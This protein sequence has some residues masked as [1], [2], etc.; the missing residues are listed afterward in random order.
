MNIDR[1]REIVSLCWCD[2]RTRRTNFDPALAD[3]FAERLMRLVNAADA[4]YMAGRWVLEDER[5][6]TTDQQQAGLW[7]DLRSALGFKPGHSTQAVDTDA[8][9]R[10]ETVSMTSY[11]TDSDDKLQPGPQLIFSDDV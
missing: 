7:E 5:I 11:G 4:L 8:V 2:S 9:S 10:G 1:A 6:Q 3:V